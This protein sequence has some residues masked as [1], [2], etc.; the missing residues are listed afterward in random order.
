MIPTGEHG[1]L[2]AKLLVC[3]IGELA[4]DNGDVARLVRHHREP[5]IAGVC[6]HEAVAAKG[7]IDSDAADAGD[8]KAWHR[9]GLRK[10]AHCA[11]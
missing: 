7:D 1:M 2:E 11:R 8:F 6:Q 4:A 5:E 3:R 10:T 9:A